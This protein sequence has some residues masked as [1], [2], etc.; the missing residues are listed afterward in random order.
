MNAPYL[1]QV[2]GES[3]ADADVL[4]GELQE[5]LLDVD[6]T[7][8]VER[9]S[10][11]RG[12][13]DGGAI[14]AVILGSGATLA[15]AKG[16]RDFLSRNPRATLRFRR[17]DGTTVEVDNLAGRHVVRLAETLFSEP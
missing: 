5:T 15:I 17:P 3:A 6:P 7:A 4:V 14:L 12:H 10:G 11:S 2:A 13:L 1:L 8:S 9:R 16:I